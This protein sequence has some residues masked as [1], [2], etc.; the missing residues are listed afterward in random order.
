M[1]SQLTG[2]YSGVF[3][4]ISTGGKNAEEEAKIT[5]GIETVARQRERVLS[6]MMRWKGSRLQYDDWSDLGFGNGRG[7]DVKPKIEE[8][9]DSQEAEDPKTPTQSSQ[10]ELPVAPWRE[11]RIQSESQSPSE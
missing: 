8:G 3:S 6:A 1:H 2:D 5:S 10:T 11:G 4:K 9:D 7:C